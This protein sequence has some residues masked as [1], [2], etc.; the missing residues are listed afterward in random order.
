M[1][2]L[3]KMLAANRCMG[4]AT[5]EGAHDD[6]TPHA[7]VRCDAVATVEF[8]TLEFGTLVAYACP[9][10]A[11]KFPTEFDKDGTPVHI[12]G[13]EIFHDDVLGEISPE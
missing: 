13:I 5:R 12:M 4:I 9:E 1:L 3:E 2:K 10:H 6:L 7:P 8:I 11:P